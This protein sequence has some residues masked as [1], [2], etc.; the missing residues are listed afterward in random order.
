MWKL[1]P[2]DLLQLKGGNGERFVHLM[3]RLIRAEATCGGLAQSEIATQLRVNIRD[4]GVDTEVKQPIPRDSGGWFTVPTCWQ[5]KAVEG[6]DVD[7][8]RKKK[9]RNDLQEE[10]HKPY[11]KQLIEKGYGYRLC[12]LGDLTPEKV[13]DWEVQL[14]DEAS[15]INPNAPNPR[16]IHGGDLLPWAEQFPGVVIWLNDR[17]P[18]VFHWESWVANR[19]AVTPRYVPNSGW[20]D[21]RLQILEHVQFRNPSVGGD[22]CLFIGGA[23]GVGKTRLV[24]ECLAELEQSTALVVIVEDE[25]EARRIGTWLANDTRQ[26]AILVADECSPQARHFLNENLRG[27][28]SIG[29][30][31][32]LGVGDGGPKTGRD[33]LGSG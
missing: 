1:V 12:I 10:V 31:H 6:K 25:Q 4:G 21:V 5:F 22:P 9:K 33:L 26:F 8:K 13:Q 29:R 18:G 16:V 11:A 15:A 17:A 20:D 14:R 19:R 32:G 2:T 23:A 7:D 30:T 27:H 3:D 28:A 24:L